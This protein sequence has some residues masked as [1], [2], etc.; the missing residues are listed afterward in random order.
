[1]KNEMMPISFHY[2]GK[3]YNAIVRIRRSH[4]EQQEYHVTIMNSTLE[5]QLLGHHKF[6]ADG[7]S[8]VCAQPPH[9]REVLELTGCVGR[10]ICHA[11]QAPGRL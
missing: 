7:E 4:R 8:M 11:G 6:V 3:E 5:M 9:Q 10:A 1:M 2:K